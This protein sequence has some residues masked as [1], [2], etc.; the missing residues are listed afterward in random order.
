MHGQRVWLDDRMIPQPW[1]HG[2]SDPCKLVHLFIRDLG[3]TSALYNV[4]I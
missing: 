1:T 3:D 4:I 2:W